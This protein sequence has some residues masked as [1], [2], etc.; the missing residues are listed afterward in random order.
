MPGNSLTN[1]PR[2]FTPEALQGLFETVGNARVLADAYAATRRG[3]TTT[4]VGLPDP[5]QMLSIPAV[6]LV[7]E[8]RVLR[9]SYLGSSVPAR[10]LPKFIDLH[11]QGKLDVE[12]LLTH[13]LA[14][15]EINEGFDRLA[16]G[17]AV[18]Q[19][20]VFD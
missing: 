19:A 3:G 18:R 14:L 9:G 12:P 17:E 11:R 15:D 10:D 2:H 16:R 4:T 5:S 20:V 13:R 8:E 6:S 1:L 7:A